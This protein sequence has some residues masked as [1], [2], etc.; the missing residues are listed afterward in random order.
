MP[1]ALLE[2]VAKG[3]VAEGSARD[4]DDDAG[5]SAD[6]AWPPADTGRELTYEPSNRPT[7]EDD[8]GEWCLVHAM[9]S[10]D[11]GNREREQQRQRFSV[12][13]PCCL[14]PLL[15]CTYDETPLPPIHSDRVVG[16]GRRGSHR[17]R[18]PGTARA[19]SAPTAAGRFGRCGNR[20]AGHG[21]QR[22]FLGTLRH[23]GEADGRSPARCSSPS[24]SG[25]QRRLPPAYDGRSGS[26]AILAGIG[27]A[28]CLSLVQIDERLE[29]PRLDRGV[30]RASR[31]PWR[32]S[33]AVPATAPA[34][35]HYISSSSPTS[36]LPEADRPLLL[37]TQATADRVA[38]PSENSRPHRPPRARM[39]APRNR[40]SR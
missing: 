5:R 38:S 35:W 14:F 4:A 8:H 3:I 16:G 18:V 29:N 25:R 24:A 17:R 2:F 19:G 11:V 34:S 32:S 12:P 26:I 13:C 22:G 6:G 21:H 31:R 33:A 9:P 23:G 10:V 27:S 40:L 7:A 15:I 28:F 20:L 1:R 30:A 37:L 36:C 39:A